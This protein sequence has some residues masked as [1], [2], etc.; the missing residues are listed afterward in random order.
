MIEDV[1]GSAEVVDRSVAFSGKVWDVETHTVRLPDGDV[2][3]DLVAHPGAVAVLALDV[4]DRVL[5]VHQYRHPAAGTL[6]ELPAGLLDVAGED[7]LE[8][9][10]RE[11]AEETE[12]RADTWS[13]LIDLLP[14]SG[15][16]S[17]AIRVFLASGLA[18]VATTFVREAEEA[19]MT[20]RRVPFDEVV[21]SALAGRLHNATLLTAVLALDAARRRGVEPRDAHRPFDW[22]LPPR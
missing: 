7:P 18:P 15:G 2:R 20:V 16:S 22:H 1:L 13:L 12:T 11:L 14:F 17:E 4:D 5:L 19:Q 10:K 21:A 6:W 9:A 8:A 3:R